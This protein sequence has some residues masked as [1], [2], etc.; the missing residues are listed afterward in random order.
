LTPNRTCVRS[1]PGRAAL[2]D[3]IAH[4][5]PAERLEGRPAPVVGVHCSAVGPEPVPLSSRFDHTLRDPA[6]CPLW[7]AA[8][9][10]WQGCATRHTEK[11]R[12]RAAEVPR[13]HKDAP[14]AAAAGQVLRAAHP[15]M[16]TEASGLPSK[17]VPGSASSAYSAPRLLR[18]FRRDHLGG[19]RTGVPRGVADANGIPSRPTR[20]RVNAF[21]SLSSPA[22]G[23]DAFAR[24]APESRVQAAPSA[25]GTELNQRVDHGGI[26]PCGTQRR[27]TSPPAD[28]RSH[29]SSTSTRV[30]LP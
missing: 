27:T 25:G 12:T 1:L 23:V 3:K 4:F 7:K 18:S 24:Q 9:Q 21:R 10:S 15:R 19:L 8:A 22:R 29:H 6:R 2:P 14:L 16:N 17:R 13:H 26:V 30:T 20:R 5:L 11:P 28:R